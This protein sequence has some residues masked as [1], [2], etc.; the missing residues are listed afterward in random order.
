MFKHHRHSIRLK[1][2]DYSSP[3]AY[4][5]TVCTKYRGEILGKISGGDMYLNQW[6]EIV[7]E[8]WYR[9]GKQRTYIQ[10]DEFIVMPDHVHGIIIITG[11]ACRGTAR[12]APTER[13]F[14]KSIPCS[15]PAIVGA[16][17]SAVTKRINRIRKMPGFPVW[18]RNYFD[19]I[20]RDEEEMNQIRQYIRTNPEN[21]DIDAENPDFRKS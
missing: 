21:W 20:I 15:L 9:T 3:G 5:V 16:F 17:K 1:D 18:Q 6:G 19:H 12:R 11:D 8:E 10:L 14:G 13:T 4:F 2:Y 7:E